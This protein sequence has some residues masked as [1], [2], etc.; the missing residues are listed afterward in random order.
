MKKT[1]FIAAAAAGL[2]AGTAQAE[3]SGT[4]TATSDYVFRGISQTAEDP[5][6]QASLDYEA[7]VG[8]YVGIWGSNVDF[9]D[10][11]DENLEI[12]YYAGFTAGE[13]LEWDFGAVYYT[14]PGA[15]GDLNYPEIYGGTTYYGGDDTWDLGAKLWA[16]WDWF[17]YDEYGYYAE[18]NANYALP[19]FGIGVTAHYGYTF[20]DGPDDFTDDS[21]L[22][23]YSDWWLGINRSFGPVDFEL[24]Y[25]DTDLD[26]D[27]EVN[28]GAGTNDDRFIFSVSTTFPW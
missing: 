1:L 22:E 15:D 23:E 24:R 10:C 28:S 14:Y 19:W 20:G 3:F 2:W 21:G 6:L 25:V 5:A 9:D 8:I 17:G 16:S 12:D 13:T 7:D 26:G 4:V 27:L 11:C 18:V